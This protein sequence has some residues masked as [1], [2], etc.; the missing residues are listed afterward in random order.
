MLHSSE[1]ER[2][3]SGQW[4]RKG[5]WDRRAGGGECGSLHTLLEGVAGSLAVGHKFAEKLAAAEE[6]PE[7]P[8][9]AKA[10]GKK[11]QPGD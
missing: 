6:E 1:D 7:H 10:M 8:C 5:S 2:D 11:L 4:P 9:S 3:L